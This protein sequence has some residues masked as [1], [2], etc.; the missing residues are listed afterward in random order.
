MGHQ[1]KI[2]GRFQANKRK[3]FFAQHLI[4]LQNAWPQD[5][6]VAISKMSLKG[7]RQ[8]LGRILRLQMMKT[9]K[10]GH[11]LTKYEVCT[12]SED[13]LGI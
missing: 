4:N 5:I 2:K 3:Y 10:L 13:S 7:I 9:A 12:Y 1:I 8:I 11:P 6:I